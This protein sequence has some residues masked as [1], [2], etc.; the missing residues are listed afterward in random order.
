VDHGIDEARIP[1]R[2]SAAGFGDR[3]TRGRREVAVAG[4]IE[5]EGGSKPVCIAEPVFRVDG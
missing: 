4:V 5:A 1:R 3:H 2:R